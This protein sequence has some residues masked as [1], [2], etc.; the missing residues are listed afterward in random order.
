[1]LRLVRCDESV[2]ISTG[3][4]L[5]KSQNVHKYTVCIA[6]FL[7]LIKLWGKIVKVNDKLLA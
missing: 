7:S 2:C 3:E 4:P 5:K 1:M 6:Y